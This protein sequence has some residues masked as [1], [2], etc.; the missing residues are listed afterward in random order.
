ML[1]LTDIPREALR[2][3]LLRGSIQ[4][5]KSLIMSNPRQYGSTFMDVLA[6]S[7]RPQTLQTLIEQV[8]RGTLL[9]PEQIESA[10]HELEKLLREEQ[11]V[12]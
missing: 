4:M 12:T 5:I 8:N 7:V 6:S 10:H 9:T 11:V 1:N 3:A 2:K